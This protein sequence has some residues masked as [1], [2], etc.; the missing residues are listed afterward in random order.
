VWGAPCCTFQSY[1]PGER[2]LKD[3]KIRWLSGKRVPIVT[4]ANKDDF[5]AT[6]VDTVHDFIIRNGPM[7]GMTLVPVGCEMAKQ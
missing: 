4:N 5:T 2:D 6:T 1:Y 7:K 3:L